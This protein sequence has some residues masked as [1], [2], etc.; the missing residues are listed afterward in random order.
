MLANTIMDSGSCSVV[1]SGHDAVTR[2][3]SSLS[4]ALVSSVRFFYESEC[5]KSRCGQ[6]LDVV[7]SRI[8]WNSDAHAKTGRVMRERTMLQRESGKV[9]TMSKY[10]LK[11]K[12]RCD[13]VP[14]II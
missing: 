11:V 3:N 2:S 7:T 13:I 6:G 5:P 10:N 12:L 9:S 8:L 14:R 4:A 1:D